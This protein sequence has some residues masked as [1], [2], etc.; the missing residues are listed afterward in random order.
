MKDLSRREH[1]GMPVVHLKTGH[2]YFLM[3][4]VL[5]CTNG[6]ED[7]EMVLYMN[8]EG[9]HFVR[10]ANEFWEKFKVLRGVNHF[11]LEAH[12]HDNQEHTM[13]VIIPETN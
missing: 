1:V 7:T 11:K 13:H 12:C 3:N 10:E 6:R 4:K 8:E 5:D 2:I 9:V